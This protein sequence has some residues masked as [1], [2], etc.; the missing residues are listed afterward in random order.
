[1]R[2]GRTMNAILSAEEWME[3]NTPAIR[4]FTAITAANIADDYA[5]YYSAEVNKGLV[6]ALT[7]CKNAMEQ[8]MM[9][10]TAI[11]KAN[12]ALAAARGV[13]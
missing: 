9:Y 10:H 2:G 7:Y 8:E 5:R 11:E 4:G 12:G 13:K 1:M 3:E 6:E